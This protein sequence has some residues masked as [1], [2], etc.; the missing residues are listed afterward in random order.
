[1]QDINVTGQLLSVKERK[2]K[3]GGKFFISR[4]L[5][6]DQVGEAFSDQAPAHKVGDPVKTVIRVNIEKKTI[7]MGLA[8]N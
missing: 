5:I 2:K 4:I 3:D 8:Q 7:S 6:G 1:M